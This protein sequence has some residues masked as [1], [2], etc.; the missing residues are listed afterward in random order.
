[1]PT[2]EY[3]CTSCGNAFEAFQSITAKPLRKCP[4]CGKKVQRLISAGSGFL[5]K[6]SGFYSTDYRSKEYQQQAKKEKE[7]AAPVK[8]DSKKEKKAKPSKKS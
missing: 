8:T 3:E 2:Y 6:G 7:S 5:F 1:M 4:K